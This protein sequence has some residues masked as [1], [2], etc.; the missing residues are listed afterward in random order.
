MNPLLLVFLLL[1]ASFALSELL[2][3]KPQPTKP[4]SIE[5]FQ[6]EQVDEGT[7]QT[8][9]FGDCWQKGWFVL[10]YGDLRSSPIKSKGGKK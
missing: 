5:D 6:I 8:V 3:K 2:V 1:V 4:A 9:F 10:W 7:P